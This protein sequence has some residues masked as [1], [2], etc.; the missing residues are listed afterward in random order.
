M[1]SVQEYEQSKNHFYPKLKN[2]RNF[3]LHHQ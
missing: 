2:E 3:K 1:Y